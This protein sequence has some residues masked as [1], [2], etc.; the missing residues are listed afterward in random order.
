M[1][2]QEEESTIVSLLTRLFEP[3]D[4]AITI[5]GIPIQQFAQKT[6]REFFAVV[7]QRPFLFHDTVRENIRFG[8]TYDEEM[9]RCAARRA[10]AEE[11]ICSLPNG[12]DT[13]LAEAGKTLSG[14]Q[15]Q[16]MAIARAL[17]KQ[18]PILVLDEATS[19]LDTAS[20]S[21]I[22]QALKELKGTVTQIVIAHRLS[23]IED[24]DRIIVID[25]GKKV[26][27]GTKDDLLATCPTFQRLYTPS[28]SNLGL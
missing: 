1:A 7:P 26:G 23:T 16:R 3:Q 8:R 20:E 12:Y 9:V 27:D 2:P 5:D 6:L 15:Q 19:S 21:H 13:V 10:H 14:G 11:F 24:A 28:S 17:V 25:R 22:K 18:S 4:G